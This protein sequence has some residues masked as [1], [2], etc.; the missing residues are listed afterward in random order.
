MR[1]ALHCGYQMS[2]G[3][4]PIQT[5]CITFGYETGESQWFLERKDKVHFE[6]KLR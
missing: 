1:T 6:E 3:F 5:W 4:A 2:F